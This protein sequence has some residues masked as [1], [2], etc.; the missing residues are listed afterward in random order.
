MKEALTQLSTDEVKVE[1][2]HAGVGAITES[3]IMLASASSA[4]AIGFHVRP[5]TKG[6]ALAERERVEVKL[7]RVIYELIDDV[8][9]AMKGMLAPTTREVY[10]GRA[11]VRATFTISKVGLI[12]GC[13]VVDGKITRSAKVRLLRENVVVADVQIA[14]LKRVKDDAREVT[15]GLECGIGLEGKPEI[16]AGDVL[17]AYLIETV[18][19]E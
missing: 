4:I 19:S 7:Y 3:D 14:S 15:K 10:L 9:R 17:E 11:E 1:V 18:A 6:I 5:E 16:R 2:L 8:K 13:H 12:A